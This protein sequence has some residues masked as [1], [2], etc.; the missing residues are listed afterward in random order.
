MIGQ[1]F[2]LVQPHFHFGIAAVGENVRSVAC[3][4]FCFE[5]CAVICTAAYCLNVELNVRIF[6][7]K[8][9]SQL[10]QAF[11]NLGFKLKNGYCFY[12][13]FGSIAALIVAAAASRQHDA[14]SQ[15]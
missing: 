3:C 7:V 4:K 5:R 9:S 1:V 8:F 10:V 12:F 14:H 2:E 11:N 15:H 13:F 6:F